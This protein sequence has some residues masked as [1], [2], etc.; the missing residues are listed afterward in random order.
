[1]TTNFLPATGALLA[2]ALLAPLP[3]FAIGRDLTPVRM[4]T[5]DYL[6]KSS[7]L[8]VTEKGFLLRWSSDTHDYGTTTDGEG[9]P[10]LPVSAMP[11]STGRL[12][13]NRNGCLAF[14]KDGLTD[15]NADGTVL[16]NVVFDAPLFS[17]AVAFNGTNF[18]LLGGFVGSGFTGRIV[19]QNGHVLTTTKLPITESSISSVEVTASAD[20]GFTIIVADVIEGLYAMQISAAGQLTGKVELFAPG[21]RHSWYLLTAATNA[22]QTV[23]AWTTF[24]ST[25]VHTVALRDGL[26]VRDTVLPPGVERSEKITLLPS[27][28]GFILLR[29][30]TVGSAR[31]LLGLRLDANGEPRNATPTLILNGSYGDVAANSRTLVV[32]GAR[33][34]LNARAIELTATIGDSGIVPSATYDIVATAVRQFDPAVASDGVDFFSAWVETTSTTIAIMAGRTTRSGL[35]L[36][37]TGFV[38]AE[39]PSSLVTRPLLTPSVSFGGGVYLVVYATVMLPNFKVMGRRYARDGTP[40]DAAPFVIGSNG[41]EPSVAFGGGRF[42]VAWDIFV[43]NKIDSVVGATVGTDGPA[44]MEHLLTPAPALELPEESGMVGRPAIGWNGRHFIVACSMAGRVRML[45][46]SPLGIPLDAHTTA[47]PNEVGSPAIA[48]SDQECLVSAGRGFDLMAAVV[49]DDAGLRADAPKI[50]VNGRPAPFALTFDGAS[51]ILAWRTGDAAGLTHIT[52]GGEP[53]GSAFAATVNT[54]GS[55]AVSPPAISANSAG[56]TAIVTTEFSMVWLIDRARLYFTPEF[57]LPRR[58]ATL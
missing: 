35:P 32:L 38:V 31:R 49:H 30:A 33:D 45:R 16:R 57:P 17:S 44:D 54:N 48:C 9:V 12:F 14:S 41:I 56:D 43:A 28:S 2:L 34:E 4:A 27:G 11:P 42:L 53:Y 50:A 52:R 8:C 51:Y 7:G 26:I 39:S 1:M 46:T 29:N 19:D 55:A 5:P 37:G 18:F 47:V 6:M 40:I 3:S 36:D 23:V 24:G 20:G 15:L 13:P 21:D 22:S 10:R 25:F 58:R